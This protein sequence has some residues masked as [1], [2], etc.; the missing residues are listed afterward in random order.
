MSNVINGKVPDTGLLKGSVSS[1]LGKDGYSAYEVAVKNGFEGSE[2]E[3]LLSLKGEPGEPGEPGI[4]GEK[5]E[6]GADGT[7]TFADLTEEQKASLKGDKGDT[8]AAGKDG[9]NGKDGVDGKAGADGK[10]GVSPVV[11]VSK[12]GKE[13]TI[14]IT[15]AEGTKTATILDGEDGEDGAGGGGTVELDTTLTQ[16]GK[17]ADA[18]AVGDSLAAKAKQPLELLVKGVNLS[19]VSLWTNSE[20]TGKRYTPAE[21]YNESKVRDVTLKFIVTTFSG[22]KADGYFRYYSAHIPAP[23]ST[24]DYVE[25]A[26]HYGYSSCKWTPAIVKIGTNSTNGL[27]E[28]TITDAEWVG[29]V[30]TDSTL[31]QDGFPADA[32]KVGDRLTE[33]SEQI[34]NSGGSGASDLLNEHGF[35]KQEVLPPGYGYVRYSENASIN[36]RVTDLTF[37]EEDGAYVYSKPVDQAKAGE[38]YTVRYNGNDYTC[39]AVGGNDI[40]GTNDTIVFGNVGALAGEEGTGEPFVIILNYGQ[41]FINSGF[42]AIVVPLDGAE[43][44]GNIIITGMIFSHTKCSPDYI[45]TAPLIVNCEITNTAGKLCSA[46][47]SFAQVATAIKLGRTVVCVL[48]GSLFQLKVYE[49]TLIEFECTRITHNGNECAIDSRYI[50][51]T[52]LSVTYSYGSTSIIDEDW[53]FTLED[54]TTVTKTVV[55]G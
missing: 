10:D 6:K 17:A 27:T 32:K 52:E 36:I 29:G 15:D 3:W 30:E 28:T 12:V 55:L 31:T 24:P 53:T 46:T 33:L 49:D 19:S 5:G 54:G 40:G 8:G 9:T 45:P 26:G 37:D 38:T 23:E 47:A 14:T 13:T 18:K 4:Q 11:S 44:T 35:L 22:D 48:D 1:I 20:S 16:E 50:T 51:F 42:G 2:A 41:E 25:F 21:I 34:A 7:M 43:L 39:T